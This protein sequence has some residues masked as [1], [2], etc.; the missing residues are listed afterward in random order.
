MNK[1]Y[2]AYGS[3]LNVRQMRYRCPEARIVGISVIKNYELLYKGSKT[4]AYLTIEKKKGSL[5]PIAVWEVSDADE[6]RL[7]IYEGFPDFYYKKNVR[8]PV[9]LIRNSKTKELDAFVYIMHEERKLG[10][11]TTSY[12]R[13]CEEGYRNFGFDNKFLDEAYEISAKEVQK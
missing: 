10:V 11:P 5:V 13:T 8:L 12:I 3:N 1:Y 9:K 7:D 6:S 2:L 4:G